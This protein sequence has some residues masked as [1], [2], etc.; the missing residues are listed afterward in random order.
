MKN[1]YV[2]RKKIKGRV[3]LYLEGRAWI[4]GKSRR[5]WQ[6]YLGSEENL[7]NLNISGLISKNSGQVESETLEFGISAALWGIA[8]EIGLSELISDMV[9]KRNQGLPLG[10][11]LT[12]AAIN[13]CA[14]PCSKSKLAQWLKGDWLGIKYNI[15]PE[16]LNAQSY[17]NHFNYLTEERMEKIQLGLVQKVTEKYGLE[18]EGLLY[19]PT[20]FFTFSKGGRGWREGNGSDMLRFGNNKEKRNDKRQVAFWLVCDRDSGIPL[21]HYCYP[22]NCQD[23][24][25]F[26]E[27]PKRNDAGTFSEDE[28]LGESVPKRL[29][30]YLAELGIDSDK[31][32]MVFDNGNLSEDGMGEVEQQGLKFI[33]SRRP[34]THKDLLA[35]PRS[36][37]TPLV[38]TVTGKT[39]EYYKTTRKIYGEKRVVYATLDPSKQKKKVYEFRGKLAKKRAEVED[40]F[41]ERLDPQKCAEARGQGQKWLKRAEVE[42][43]VKTL[44]GRAPFRD[45]LLA[46]IEGPDEVDPGQ[47]DRLQL[48]LEI[49]ENAQKEH[50]ATLG[51]SI[52]F[53]NQG[54]WTPEEVIWGY[55]QQYI[56]EHA[57]RSMKHPATIAVRPMYHHSNVTISGHVFI[58][59]IAYL[60]LSI[61]RLKLA[62]KGCP[63]SFEEIL[64]AL[65]CVHLTLLFPS[66]KPSPVRVIDRVSGLAATI[67]KHLRLKA[68]M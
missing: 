28:G 62:R 2:T 51:R 14:A 4:D 25:V 30:R 18:I 15:D 52:L 57:F 19:D 3:Y 24:G 22:G 55:R 31:V 43:K 38:L 64:D 50:E 65:R 60:L 23:A 46:R 6:K 1:V 27:M 20:N 45:I 13:R 29:H 67:V 42:K 12:I 48:V 33:A 9:G 63:A 16:C 34:S 36:E 68:L 49:D 40:F 35:V 17:W 41:S 47:P 32:T 37:F 59:F 54:E 58:C 8:Q 10:D 53:T 11:Y 61:L 66:D 7:S 21:F 44:I 5:T 39:V 26:K 56:V